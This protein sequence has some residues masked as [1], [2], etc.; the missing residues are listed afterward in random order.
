MS[1]FEERH[2]EADPAHS[3][4]GVIYALHH[5]PTP[6]LDLAEPLTITFVP[7]FCFIPEEIRSDPVRY[8]A[9]LQL[10]RFLATPEE[11]EHPLTDAEVGTAQRIGDALDPAIRIIEDALDQFREIDQGEDP[12]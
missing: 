1:E 7:I 8:E 5:A 6:Q 4:S 12:K 9:L 3:Y 2:A 11:P 10:A